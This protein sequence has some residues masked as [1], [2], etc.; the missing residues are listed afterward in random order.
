MAIDYPK[1]K[2]AA[3]PGRELAFYQAWCIIMDLQDAGGITWQ[4]FP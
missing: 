1:V 3:G 2:P 4:N